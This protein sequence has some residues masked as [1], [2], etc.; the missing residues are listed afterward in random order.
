MIS[1]GQRQPKTKKHILYQIT[2]AR[3]SIGAGLQECS[4]TMKKQSEA[5]RTYLIGQ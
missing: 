1:S 5:A 2:S 4:L 3:N